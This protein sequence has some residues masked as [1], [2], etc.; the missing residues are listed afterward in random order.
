MRSS[1][2]LHC[3][4]RLPTDAPPFRS[5]DDLAEQP[6]VLQSGMNPSSLERV[7]YFRILA[8]AYLA[9][10]YLAVAYLAVAYRAVRLLRLSPGNRFSQCRASVC[11]RLR[12]YEASCGLNDARLHWKRSTT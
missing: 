5:K 2:V 12:G 8:V 1:E 3:F 7:A 6:A 9:V 10:A 4:S 11:R